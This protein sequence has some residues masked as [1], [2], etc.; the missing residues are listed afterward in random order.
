MTRIRQLAITLMAVATAMFTTKVFAIPIVFT[1]EFPG[2]FD[3]SINGGALTASGPITVTGIVDNTTADIDLDPFRGEFPLTSVIFT[4]AG[5]VDRAVTTPLS[6]LIFFDNFSFQ[7]EG[8]FNEG[9]IGWNKVTSSGDFMTDIND[10]STLVAL[11]YTTS[12]TSTFW[13]DALGEN[14]W[15]LDGGVTIGADLGADGPT[16]TFSINN[17][18]EPASLLL[19]ASGLVGLLVRRR[20]RNGMKLSGAA[21]SQCK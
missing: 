13:L 17:I 12:G 7:R 20:D 5:F 1:L 15:I 19:L 14:V 11:P 9:I 18:P 4:G 21:L 8:E 6:L 16:G 3:V 2:G 10:L